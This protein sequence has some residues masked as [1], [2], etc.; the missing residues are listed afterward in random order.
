MILVLGSTGFLGKVVCNALEKKNIVY[1]G[2]SKS[3]GVDLR[4]RESFNKYLSDNMD[5]N[6]IINCAS[7]SGGLQFAMSNPVDLYHNNMTMIDSIYWNAYKHGV[8]K[9]INPISNCV[10]PAK[11]SLFKEDELWDGPLHE[12]VYVY[13]FTRRAELVCS[14]AYQKQYKLN[15][16]NL[17]MS[18]MY[19]E[20]DH[21]DLLRSHALGAL[22]MRFV[23]AQL[24]NV[25]IVNVW[26][27]GKAIREWLYVKDAADAI[28]KSLNVTEHYQLIN[29]GTGVG[30]SM[31]D[32]ITK[33]AN[34]VGFAGEIKYDLSM[35]DGAP[36]KTVD[37]TLGKQLLDYCPTTSLDEGIKQTIEW[38]RR[39]K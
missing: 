37:G 4:D 36:H 21:F 34:Y 31:K 1:K 17:V 39:N 24:H 32:L 14:W 22:I 38:Y 3:Q 15:S 28:I 25:P 13:G 5:I 2:V 29:I 16:I 7:F 33:I 12:S 35:P 26:G 19:G 27:S 8:T 30:I 6:T 10:Y 20:G 9:I 23:E 11:A 18:N